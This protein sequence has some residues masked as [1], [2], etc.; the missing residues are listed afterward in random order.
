MMSAPAALV[1]L[2]QPWADVYSHSTA[3]ST[4][5]TFLHIAAL[6]FGGGIAIA[7]DRGTLRSLRL[8][9]SMRGTHLDELGALHR[10]VLIG[11]SL[12]LFTGLLLL[13]A[14]LDTFFGSWVF[15][16][17][18]VLV[19]VLLTNGFLMT[20][21]ERALRAAPSPDSSHW[22]VLRRSAVMS[23]VLWFVITLAGVILVNAG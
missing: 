1:R 22:Q 13:A 19:A 18:M 17:K 9:A 21:A 16:T 2:V 11:L 7:A 20:R 5:V 14:D 12:S 15:W 4:A 6:L 8:E 10:V 23:L 3:V